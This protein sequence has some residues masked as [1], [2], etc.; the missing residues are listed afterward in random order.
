MHLR[1]MNN[2]SKFWKE[3]ENVCPDNRTAEKWVKAHG[4][5]LR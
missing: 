4:R 3:V 5:L 2:S 1:Q